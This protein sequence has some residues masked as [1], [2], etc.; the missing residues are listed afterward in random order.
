MSIPQRSAEGIEKKERLDIRAQHRQDRNR[1][2]IVVKII[3][4]SIDDFM[5]RRVAESILLRR[6]YRY[7][8]LVVSTYEPIRRKDK[9]V[10]VDLKAMH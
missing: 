8:D 2:M 10:R 5:S 4:K 7:L 6:L 1:N 3:E 9:V